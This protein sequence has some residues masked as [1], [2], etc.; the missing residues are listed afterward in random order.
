[1]IPGIMSKAC[2]M[3]RLQ[4]GLPRARIL[5]PRDAMTAF[6]S[7]IAVLSPKQRLF[8]YSVVFDV[9]FICA[10]TAP[11]INHNENV[12]AGDI[13]RYRFR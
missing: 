7:Q 2:R 6:N 8:W 13:E 1:M 3:V 12:S 4:T 5:V 11:R 9:Q 10:S